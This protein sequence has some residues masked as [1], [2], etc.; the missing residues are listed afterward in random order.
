MTRTVELVIVGADRRAT[1]RAIGAARS[2]LRVLMTTRSSRSG[3]ARRVHRA[4]RAA[5]DD[6]RQRISVLTGAEIVCV[7][8]VGSVEAGVIRRLRTGQLMVFNAN[9]ILFATR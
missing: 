7:D 5:G 2:G 8:G 3:V 1:V 4:L 9:A 6:V